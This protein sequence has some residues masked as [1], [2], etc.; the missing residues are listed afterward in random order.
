MSH[1]RFISPLF[2]FFIACLSSAGILRIADVPY[3]FSIVLPTILFIHFQA[4]LL[5]IPIYSLS[6]IFL[7]DTPNSSLTLPSLSFHLF[8]IVP[9]PSI[10]FHSY[11]PL[12]SIQI[13]LWPKPISASPF[14]PS[15]KLTTS[16]IVPTII[17]IGAHPLG[18]LNDLQ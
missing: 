2:F 5:H 13:Q 11:C 15:L 16:L 3:T 9:F 6:L 12:I 10:F 17:N 8:S 14:S 1:Y 18:F 7:M 4:L